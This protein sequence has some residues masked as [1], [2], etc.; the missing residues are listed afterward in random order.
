MI[1][2][3]Y[4]ARTM[5]NGYGT[6]HPFTRGT[7]NPL[8][9]FTR[10]HKMLAKVDRK[11]RTSF[12]LLPCLQLPLIGRI[13]RTILLA[14]SCYLSPSLRTADDE[15]KDDLARRWRSC[16]GCRRRKFGSL[17]AFPAPTPTDV[18]ARI[19]YSCSCTFLF[20]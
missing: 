16:D 10:M 9:S 11:E 3:R 20:R 17:I 5:A 14:L 1:F 8:N 12:F 13:D 18:R 19:H 4:V 6:I 15:G 2:P 7:R